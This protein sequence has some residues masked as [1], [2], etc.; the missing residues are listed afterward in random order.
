MPHISLEEYT[1]I[2]T[3]VLLESAEKIGPDSLMGQACLTRIDHII[4]FVKAWKEYK[5]K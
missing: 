3:K 2:Y 5:A 4:D 1:K